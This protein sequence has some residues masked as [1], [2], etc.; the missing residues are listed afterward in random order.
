MKID[1][2]QVVQMLETAFP[3]YAGLKK[4]PGRAYLLNMKTFSD[5]YEFYGH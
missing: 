3:P 2:L 1:T 5:E 4:G